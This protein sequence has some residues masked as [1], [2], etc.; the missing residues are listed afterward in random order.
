MR[1]SPELTGDISYRDKLGAVIR[2][3]RYQPTLVI[4]AIALSV[5]AAILEGFGLSFIVPIIELAQGDIN[6]DEADGLL[7]GF[8]TL[9]EIL[10]LPFTLGWLVIGVS[11]IMTVRYTGSFLVEWLSGLIE[12]NY[13]RHLQSVTFEQALSADVAYFDQVGSDEILNTIVT[14]TEYAARVLRYVIA[15]LEKATLSIIYLV[16]ALIISPILTIAAGIAFLVFTYVFRTVF[17]NAYSIGDRVADANETIQRNAQAGTQGI[18]DVKLFGMQNELEKRFQTAL[19]EFTNSRVKYFRNSAAFG[20]YYNLITAI[21]LFVL[22]YA[23]LVFANLTVAE[24]GIFL[25]AMFRL[26]PTL[27]R[28]NKQLYKLEGELPHLLRT[29]AFVDDLRTNQELCEANS[30][31]P[32]RIDRITFEAVSF[33]YPGDEEPTLREVSFEIPRGTFVAF[34][35]PSGAGKST[36]VSLLT[37]LYEPS[38]GTISANGTSISAFDIDEWRSRVT[39]VRQQPYIFN[40]TLREN[41]TIGDRTVPQSSID[42]ACEIAQVTEFFDDLPAGYDTHLG[43]EG[44]RLSGGQRQRVAI[45]RALIKGGEIVI[46][47]EATSELDTHLEERVHAAIE[48]RLANRTL[49]VIAHRLSTVTNADRIYAIDDGKIRES[50]NHTELVAAGRGYAEVHAKQTNG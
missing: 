50:G 34:V 21:M 43:D 30:Q 11:A 37:R 26:G 25:F 33:A 29:Q 48:E 22:I 41:L 3:F 44:V 39:V 40:A 14:Q 46:F 24:L 28:L 36:I 20:N 35:G 2:A 8:V 5:I 4:T 16:I 1:T 38:V 6:A 17:E 45:A 13:T 19:I 31:V 27:S 23:G 12:T 42:E 9:Y 7:G 47:D 18:R 15:A 49:I 32:D 10:G